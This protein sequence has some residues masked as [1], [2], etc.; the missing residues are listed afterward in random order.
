M[1]RIRTILLALW[2]D[3]SGISA[4]EYAMLTAVVAVVVLVA[5][6][7]LSDAVSGSMSDTT[8]CLDGTAPKSSC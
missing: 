1:R 2:R 4:T 7:Q 8:D 6:G 5:V 3:R